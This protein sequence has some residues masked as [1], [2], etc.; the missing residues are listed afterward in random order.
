MRRWRNL[1]GVAGV[2]GLLAAAAGCSGGSSTSGAVTLT[3]Y[4]VDAA[5]QKVWDSLLASWKRDNN[6]ELKFVNYTEDKYVPQVQNAVRA[7]APLDVIIANGQDVRTFAQQGWLAPL[8]GI[9]TTA[10]LLPY[11]VDPFEVDGKLY[12]AGVG[13]ATFTSTV[14]NQ[15]LMQKYRLDSPATFDAVQADVAKLKD[16]GVALFAEPGA[17]LYLWPIWFMQ[18]IQQESGGK[19]TDVTTATLRDHMK[20]TDPMYVKALQDLA[21][22]GSSGALING[23]NGLSKDNATTAVLEQKTVCNFGIDSIVAVVDKA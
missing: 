15:T 19:P 1:L 22:F 7:G 17:S 18:T 9:V 13:S 4:S 16:T 12:A 23:F 21:N 2:A 20:F 3:V 14:C 10:D 6:V 5:H 8:D 11:S